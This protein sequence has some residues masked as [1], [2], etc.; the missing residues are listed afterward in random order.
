MRKLGSLIIV[1][2]SVIGFTLQTQAQPYQLP[3]SGFETWSGTANNAEPVNFNSFATADCTIGGIMGAIAC[4]S[5]KTPHHWKVSGKRTGG[6]GSY[7][8]TI[9]STTLVGVVA[10]GNMTLGQI[11]VGSTTASSSSNFNYT[12]RSDTLFS[13]VFSATPDSIYVWT[14]FW[15]ASASSQARISAIIHGNTDF[16]D[17]NDLNTATAY[18]AKA[19]SQF[20]RTGSTAGAC[21]WVQQKVPFQYTGSSTR[22]YFLLTFTN[23]SIPGGG[24][25]GDSLSIDDIELIY[26]A[27]ITDIKLNS[28]T[29][30]GFNIGTF[31][32][33]IQYPRGTNPSVFPTVTYTTEV[34]DVSDTLITYP[35]KNNGI[36]SARS[37]ITVVAEDGVTQKVY[38]INYSIWKS[39]DSTLS[40]LGYT[41]SGTDTVLIPGFVSSQKTY[42]ISFPPGTV[43]VPII[44]YAITSDTGARVI[45][46]VQ[47]T[48]PNGQAVI[49][50]RSENGDTAS[51]IVNFSV[52]LS[53]NAKLDSLKYNGFQVPG[54]HP[55]TLNYHVIL[56][57][58]TSIVPHVT[59]ITQWKGLTPS[60]TA[61]SVL[62]GTTTIVVTAEDGTTSRT[63]T[64]SF[65]VALSTNASASWIKY[66]G[67]SLSSFHA[68]TL[69]YNVELPYGTSSVNVTAGPAWATAQTSISN[70]SV[71]P[72]TASVKI[73][74]EDTNYTKTYI[75]NFTVAK[76][77]NARLDSLAYQLNSIRTFV[78]SFVD[79]VYNY[80]VV[81]PPKTMIT[82]TIY[83]VAQDT[84]ASVSITNPS[85]PNDTAFIFITAENGVSTQ[86]Y[87]VVFKVML[88]TNANLSSLKL[89]DT[90]INGF[91]ASVLN[92]YVALDSAI[93]PIVTAITADT[94]ARYSIS[95]PG[96][97]PGIVTI[98]VKAEDTTISKIYKIYLTVKLSNNADLLDL[99]YTLNSVPY[100]IS[101][102]HKDT[103]VYHVLLPSQTSITPVVTW[104]K[105]DADAS[106]AVTQP[107]SPND[108]GII[109]VTSASDTVFK[110]YYVFFEVEIST[111]AKLSS[112]SV[113][114]NAMATFHA[115][116]TYYH[117]ILHYDSIIPPIVSVVPQSGAAHISIQQALTVNDSA[118]ITVLAEDSVHTL[119]YVVHF[120]RQLSPVATLTNI[121]YKLGT[122]DSIVHDFASNVFIYTIDLKAETV[123]V[124]DS[125]QYSLTDSRAQAQIIR[126][127]LHVND[128]AIIKVIAENMIDSNLYTLIFHRLLSDNV[129][130]DTIKINGI[131]MANFNKDSLSYTVILPW[132]TSANPVVSAIASWN[133]STLQFTQAGSYFGQA[134]VQV[135]AE[136]GIH[137]RTYTI[138]FVQ[139][140]NVDLQT[141][142]YDLGGV[143]YTIAN[144]NPA[145]T[146]Y[147]VMLPIGTTDVPQLN[148][149]L[150]D[151]R[152]SVDTIPA[153][154]PNGQASL[155]ITGWDMLHMKTYTVNFEVALSTDAHLIDLLVD[156]VSLPDFHPDTLEY[157]IEYAY[158][159]SQ[160]P[161]V[162]AIAK[163][164]D[165]QFE[166]TQ[167]TAF[168]ETAIIRVKAGD[169]NITMT[170]L[171]HFSIEAGDNAYLSELNVNDI[172]ISDF[173]KENLIYT[174]VLPYGT[175]DVPV[176]TAT[177]EDSRASV[178]IEQPTSV[179]DTARIVVVAVNAKDS[180]IYEVVF[181]LALNDDA[182][183]K[184]IKVDG[185]AITNFDPEV[186]NYKY[187][188]PIDYQGIPVVTVES[189]DSNATH[190]ITPTQALPGQTVIDVVAEDGIN[191]RTYRVNFVFAN[192]IEVMNEDEKILIYPNPSRD[193]VKIQVESESAT[194]IEAQLYDLFGKKIKSEYTNNGSMVIDI[195]SFSNGMYILKINQGNKMLKSV[196]LIKY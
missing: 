122:N 13:Q 87:S 21:T 102:F 159:R 134:Q 5:A 101:T 33:N 100:A 145:D 12:K 142:S 190:L 170:Y 73:T 84:N 139:G 67:V 45:S 19:E 32:Y 176:I 70:P 9:Y 8:L 72:G 82:P 93:M 195:S 56:V 55:D 172:L 127:P 25:S 77:H 29:I 107:I 35:G 168:P 6:N 94:A 28:T 37:V 58:G 167:I 47:A 173:Q 161:V 117:V 103:L 98:T 11:R 115:D 79:T 23:N 15:A 177:P 99:G 17:P 129:A 155:I 132:Q 149:S 180:L 165:A 141:L 191:A 92:Y 81:L 111:N 183:L 109:V 88:D 68:D 91:N 1:L 114:G 64:I 43:A 162:E 181:T 125:I 44:N 171:I 153:I 116:T 119:T 24:S 121:A 169:T 86:L 136:D 138:Q 59:A 62:P 160:M 106:V 150:L 188:L 108:T 152:C 148:Y 185:V 78:H 40:S 80:T 187:E 189:E 193:I 118:I 16:K 31:N 48:S 20:T 178:R 3:N 89:N 90:L 128:T 143:N 22:N 30:S 124:P 146:V 144:F 135:I 110:T 66:N 57:P 10:N 36:D 104:Q 120:T 154:N 75:I 157:F 130:L 194:I 14:K 166:I 151:S 137:S 50:V 186:H 26:S 105:A 76:N 71:L 97:I 96:A 83:A 133:L 4:P 112:I 113:N 51:Y 54:F 123:N 175:T 27:W 126:Y 41:L 7:Y 131:P 38:T 69:N 49:K 39:S 164:I 179:S 52:Q 42:A 147:H 174:Q 196:K 192:S 34:T 61:A 60:I 163:E 2:I 85:S 95:Y 156:S 18:A 65:T 158:G 53:S 140:S 63:Y 74:A 182:R 184:F 46:I